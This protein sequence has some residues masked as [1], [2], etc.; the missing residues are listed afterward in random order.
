MDYVMVRLHRGGEL[1]ASHRTDEAGRGVFTHLAKDDYRVF[2]QGRQRSRDQFVA[3]S[4]NKI[5]RRKIV[6]KD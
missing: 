1:I 6:L 3:T 4:G 2:V 5:Y